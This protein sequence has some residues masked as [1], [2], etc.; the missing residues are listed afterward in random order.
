[1]FRP[2]PGLDVQRNRGGQGVSPV[3]PCAMPG[4]KSSI[5]AHQTPE[6][7]V[8]TAIPRRTP[9]PI[10]ACRCSPRAH[11]A[12]FSAPVVETAGQGARA[13]RHGPRRRWGP[14]HPDSDIPNHAP[15]GVFRRSSRP[16]CDQRSPSSEWVPRPR[17][18]NPPGVIASPW[19]A[20]DEACPLSP[21]RTTDRVPRVRP[22]P[23]SPPLPPGCSD[24]D[25]GQ[26]FPAGRSL[27][28]RPGSS[29]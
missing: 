20:E 16:R 14:N 24:E 12:C 3:A 28:H 8:E 22:Y 13:A 17:R 5:P 15:I 21:P 9:T 2:E 6:Q 10:W 29:L 4:M 7:I 1:L 19:P 26:D 18:P 11:D 25:P 27:P 23:R